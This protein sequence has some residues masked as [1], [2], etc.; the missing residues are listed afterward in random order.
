MNSMHVPGLGDLKEI[1]GT[2]PHPAGSVSVHY[3]MKGKKLQVAITLPEGV[4][5]RFVW[6]GKTQNLRGGKN[7]FTI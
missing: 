6:N 1:G 5:G 2:M 4:E 7:T 3:K